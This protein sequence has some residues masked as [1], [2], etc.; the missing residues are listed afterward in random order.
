MNLKAINKELK[1][2]A[3]N[4]FNYQQCRAVLYVDEDG[5]FFMHGYIKIETLE[6]VSSV[7]KRYKKDLINNN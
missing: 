6:K 7:I 1:R 5:D 3:S 4:E 2:L